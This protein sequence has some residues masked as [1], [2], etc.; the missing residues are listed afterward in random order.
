MLMVVLL[1]QQVELFMFIIVMELIMENIHL[2]KKQ[3]DNL[4]FIGEPLKNI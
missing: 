1:D 3:Q 4:V 2:Y